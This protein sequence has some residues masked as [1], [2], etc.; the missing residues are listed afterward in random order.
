MSDYFRQ[1]PGLDAGPR[2]NGPDFWNMPVPVTK[3]IEVDPEDVL[4]FDVEGYARLRD[5]LKKNKVRHV[6]LDRL[7]DRYVLLPDDGGV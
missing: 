3:D 5:F 7:R 4:V 1:F 2:Y 6:L